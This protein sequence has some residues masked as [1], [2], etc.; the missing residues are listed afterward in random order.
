[1]QYLVFQFQREV[2]NLRVHCDIEKQYKHK[3]YNVA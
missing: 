3:Y 1:M 2:Q